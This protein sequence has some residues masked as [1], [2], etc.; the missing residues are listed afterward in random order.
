MSSLPVPLSPVMS[1]DVSLSAIT[2]TKSNTPRMRALRPTTT[3]SIEKGSRCV[4]RNLVT[5]PP[6]SGTG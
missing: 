1:T 3:E 4:S 2:R 5:G 6:G